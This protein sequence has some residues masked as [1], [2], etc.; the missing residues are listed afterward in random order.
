MEPLE[1]M[2]IVRLL[3]PICGLILS[4]GNLRYEVKRTKGIKKIAEER[5]WEFSD[6]GETAQLN[7]LLHFYLFSFGKAGTK[8]IRN[9][10][11]GKTEKLNT[12]V[13]DYCVQGN[14]KVATVVYFRASDLNLP[15]FNLLRK[16]YIESSQTFGNKELDFS[17]NSEFTEKYALFT[18]DETAVRLLFS[19][20]LLDYFTQKKMLN[21]EA[22]EDRLILYCSDPIV[23]PDRID[24]FL[25][26]GQRLLE[27]LKK[28][29]NKVNA[30][31]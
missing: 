3:I 1:F 5:G 2:M 15:S 19:D 28:S 7:N 18:D 6:R 13:F 16:P 20:R 14:T 9:L 25:E 30:I 8:Q 31:A 22:A 26:E 11:Y 29:D 27:L 10:I 4:L 21:I 12:A 24:A 17:D 23:E